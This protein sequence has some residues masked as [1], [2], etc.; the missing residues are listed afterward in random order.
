M[1]KQK[2]KKIKAPR[3][4]RYNSF[5]EQYDLLVRSQD[6]LRVSAIELKDYYSRLTD[7]Y[8]QTLEKFSFGD[9]FPAFVKP[10]TPIEG[11]SFHPVDLSLFTTPWEPL[12]TDADWFIGDVPVYVAAKSART[13]KLQLKLK[14]L[15]EEFKERRCFSVFAKIRKIIQELK[16]ITLQQLSRTGKYLRSMERILL[17]GFKPNRIIFFRRLIQFLFKNMDDESGDSLLAFCTQASN[18]NRIKHYPNDFQRKSV[19]WPD[20]GNQ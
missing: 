15:Q 9:I 14:A 6:Q 13:E 2:P 1:K 5:G 18:E 10:I 8:Q 16:A 11:F 17:Y 12:T 3:V 4:K 20:R 19:G 7:K